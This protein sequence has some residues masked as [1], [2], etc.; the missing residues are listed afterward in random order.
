MNGLK[1]VAKVDEG[2]GLVFGWGIVCQDGGRPYV[3]SQGDEVPDGAM[4]AATTDFMQH[5]R[6]AKVMHAGAAVGEIVHSFP[7]TTEIAKAM[8][9]DPKGRSGWMIAMKP[10]SAEVLRKF[11][12]G[13]YSG[14]SIGGERLEE[15]A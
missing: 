12:D 5:R 6:T 10:R 8:G 11:R 3:D 1:L 4:L 2:L 15:A 13:T 7:L 14:F 9:I